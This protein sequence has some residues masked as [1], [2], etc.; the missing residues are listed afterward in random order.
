MGPTRCIMNLITS[1]VGS[2]YALKGL[3]VTCSKQALHVTC[4]LCTFV[5]LL[6]TVSGASVCGCVL[7]HAAAYEGTT[8]HL[9]HTQAEG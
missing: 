2:T 5:S 6:P 3:Q 7:V 8:S 4:S 1:W 9:T